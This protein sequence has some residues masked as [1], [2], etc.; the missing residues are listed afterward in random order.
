MEVPMR[1]QVVVIAFIVLLLSG[2]LAWRVSAEG[3]YEHAPSGGSAIVEG[4]QTFVT[5]RT[6]GRLVEVLAQEGDGVKKGQVVARLDCVE[7]TAM[8]EA[9]VAQVK[10]AQATVE[11]AAAGK[12]GAKGQV[13]VAV[14][15]ISAARAA[16]RALVAQRDLTDK[17]KKRASELHDTGAI[18]T[19]VFDEADTRLEAVEQQR[20]AAE[21]NVQTARARAAAASSSVKAAEA[22]IERARAALLAAKAD[23]KRAELA[24]AECTLSAPR[25]GTI[26][27]RL[28]EPGA[29]VGPGTRVLT[30]VDTSTARVIFFLPNAELG[31]AKIGAPALVHVD[32]Y[33]DRTFEG[34]VRRIAA[35]AEFTP[36]NVQ[37][38][39]DRDR[40]VYA[41][42]VHVENE[43]GSLRAGMPGEVVLPGTER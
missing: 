3:A 7:Q 21:A 27:A 19:A 24:V 25:D 13:G 42:E 28:L 4:V 43:D 2:A 40:L 35:E 9:A 20:L 10:A 36:R 18:S 12:S 30:L 8:L 31:R 6:G 38:R 37:T 1:I 39:E 5:V 15:Q 32:A 41:V 17:N 33:P 14:A 11:A 26:T 29:V 23:V 34:T 16:E 22:Q